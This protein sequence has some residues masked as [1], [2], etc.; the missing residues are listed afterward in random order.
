MEHRLAAERLF[1]HIETTY[2]FITAL[3]FKAL[4]SLKTFKHLVTSGQIPRKMLSFENVLAKQHGITLRRDRFATT[5]LID[6]GSG[7]ELFHVRDDRFGTVAGAL[8]DKL[9]ETYEDY[10]H[11]GKTPIVQ[12]GG[13]IDVPAVIDDFDRE[14]FERQLLPILSGQPHYAAAVA[15]YNKH[16][17]LV[18]S[19]APRTSVAYMLLFESVHAVFRMMRLDKL[20]WLTPEVALE[21][22]I[23]KETL[24]FA[25]GEEIAMLM[26]GEKAMSY[27]N[28]N[29]I[30]DSVVQ[31]LKSL[32]GEDGVEFELE[33]DGKSLLARIYNPFAYIKS[34]VVQ[35]PTI[36]YVRI[37]KAED[38][39]CLERREMGE[40][41]AAS[42]GSGLGEVIDNDALR[43][44]KSL[45]LKYVAK[46]L[47][48][49]NPEEKIQAQY[50][51]PEGEA[52]SEKIRVNEKWK[53][54]FNKLFPVGKSIEVDYWLRA[55][56]ELIAETFNVDH[57]VSLPLAQGLA[58]CRSNKYRF[59]LSDHPPTI[60]RT[61]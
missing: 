14:G 37:D 59:R 51:T 36:Q 30:K 19:A 47:N 44:A 8:Q 41:S 56:A 60:T 12:M 10:Q 7:N 24:P 35:L 61:G 23:E 13:G 34:I 46:D 33:N 39:A 15:S 25:S 42:S 48:A 38:Q 27:Y 4:C 17:A 45:M 1:A 58:Y 29:G 50:G 53:K 26:N 32:Y 2:G 6:F 28:K 49:L 31:V 9:V 54:K 20:D 55:V 52:I 18:T 5:G 3:N 57:N 21:A 43:L 16:A 40:D 11:L 22:D